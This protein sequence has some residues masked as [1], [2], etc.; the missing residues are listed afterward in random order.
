MKTKQNRAVAK[1]ALQKL[2]EA[3]YFLLIL[4]S[5][6]FLTACQS[7]K[8]LTIW[9]EGEAVDDSTA[10]ELIVLDTGFESWFLTRARPPNF[11]SQDY[12]ENWN[13]R[14]TDAWNYE[15]IGYSYSQVIHGNIDYDPTV[16]YGLEIN[17]KLFY[18]FI[19]VENEL[20]IR[21]LVDGPQAFRY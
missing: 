10:Y 16:D 11:Y 21:L 8:T 4:A 9:D 1:A 13:R 20:G 7:T 17:H 18:Y 14:Y 12:Y 15:K 6:V 5:I 3:G 2:I 19:Y